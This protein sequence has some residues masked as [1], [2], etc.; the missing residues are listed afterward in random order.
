MEDWKEKFLELYLEPSLKAALD[1]KRDHIPSKLYRYRPASGE[2]YALNEIATGQIY[3]AHHKDLN[4]PF[5][6]SSIM[7][8][9]SPSKYFRDSEKTEIKKGMAKY[10]PQDALEKMLSHENWY[11]EILRVA[12]QKDLPDQDP[13][14]VG[15]IINAVIMKEFVGINQIFND[16]SHKMSRLACFTTKPCNL[17]MWAGYAENHKGVCLEYNT[18]LIHDIYTTNRLFPVYYTDHLPDVLQFF[19]EAKDRAAVALDY[20]AIHKSKDWEYEDEWRL[21]YNA[22]SWYMGPNDVPEDFWDKGK[23]IQFIRPSRVL[24]GAKM[25]PEDEKRAREVCNK[26]NI[27]V[28]KMKIT[29]FGLQEESNTTQ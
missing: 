8:N 18:R 26:C 3:L 24:L 7:A 6:A 22:G 20:I 25:C 17:P 4:D 28:V 9:Q 19:L 21:I 12:A 29:Q 16:M 27:P 14:R 2:F 15:E 10:I 13:K 1:Y 23:V 5:D 11:E